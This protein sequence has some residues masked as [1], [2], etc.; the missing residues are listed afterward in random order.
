MD[1]KDQISYIDQST[2]K[3]FFDGLTMFKLIY[4]KID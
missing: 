2:G 3:I 4:N 1:Y